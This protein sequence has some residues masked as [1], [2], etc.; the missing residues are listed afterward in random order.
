ME[1]WNRLTA[2]RRQGE[3]DNGKKGKGLDKEH[4]CMTHG[5]GQQTVGVDSGSRGWEG[6]GGKIG[7]IINGITIKMIKIN[8][9][10]FS[11]IT[12]LI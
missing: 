5:H 11:P 7:T 3:G 2:T 10:L 9:F 6:K 4:A 12:L 1:T 8:T